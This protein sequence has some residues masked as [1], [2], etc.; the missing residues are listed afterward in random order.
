MRMC[1]LSGMR[2]FEASV[3]IR[4]SSMTEFMLS[5]QLA[6]RSPSRMIH[7][8]S[9]FGSLPR[10][11]ITTDKMPSFHSRVAGWMK[12]YSSSGMTAL[13]L[14]STNLVLRG[15]SE[16]SLRAWASDFQH[17]DLPAPDGPM[18]KTQWRISSS[19][20]SCTTLR[21]NS[22]SGKRPR[23]A[24]AFSTAASS[25]GSTLRGGSIFGKRSPRSPWKMGSSCFTI[26][27]VLKSRSARISSS[28]SIRSGSAR[29]KAPAT[30]S[31]LLTARRP[32]S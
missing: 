8:G 13:G 9:L 18:T 7:F 16:R 29:L 32:Q 31:T 1:V 23:A 11:R 3:S 22:S 19:S 30:T 15:S 20:S 12:P 24:A 17:S 14:M 28:C 5:I 6:S 27:G 21:R 10:F 4:L 25:T 26:L 2:S